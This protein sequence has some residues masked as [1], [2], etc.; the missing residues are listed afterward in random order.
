MSNSCYENISD[1]SP[2][3]IGL[4]AGY[5]AIIGFFGIVG[6]IF[7]LISLFLDKR[8]KSAINYLVINHTCLDLLQSGV[9]LPLYIVNIIMNSNGLGYELCTFHGFIS[10]IYFIGTTY[11][12]TA[13]AIF[14]YLVVCQSP[15]VKLA[16]RHAI[17]AIV[18]VWIIAIIMC[19]LPFW[20]L[21]HYDYNIIERS[22]LPTWNEGLANQINAV[23]ESLIDFGLPLLTTFICYLKI[24]TVLR[25]IKMDLMRYRCES[26]TANTCQYSSDR[27]KKRFTLTL[28]ILFL[29]FLLCFTVWSIISF[30]VYPVTAGTACVPDDLH[31]FAISLLYLNSA[32]NPLIFFARMRSLRMK[33]YFILETMTGRKQ[34]ETTLA[35]SGTKRNNTIER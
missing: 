25:K 28:S 4:R 17:Y 23:F 3:K 13:M 8:K 9:R 6:N 35:T 18:L 34:P 14:R 31:Y 15:A 24:Y 5:L 2:T 19:L 29:N 33:F 32:L 1:L 16:P 30:I 21:S 10:G 12:L 11:T 7:L 26:I 20:G 22:C 27:A